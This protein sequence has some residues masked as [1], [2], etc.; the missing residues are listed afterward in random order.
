MAGQP[1]VVRPDGGRLAASYSDGTTVV[2]QLATRKAV[3]S[4]P[5]TESAFSPAGATLASL[6]H[7][8]TV[9]VRNAETLAL[10]GTYPADVMAPAD[11]AYRPTGR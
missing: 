7:T 6:E 5:G 1:G 10:L 11:L 3:A 8:G 2:W 9:A 4:F